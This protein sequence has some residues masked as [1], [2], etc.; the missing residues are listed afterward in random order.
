MTSWASVPRPP[1]VPAVERVDIA[2]APGLEARY[3]RR[4]PVFAIG[5]HELDLVYPAR[6]LRELL[7]R[8]ASPAREAHP[9]T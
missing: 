9:W 7:D 8:A 6:Q 3:G 2:D 4:I 1:A 5:G